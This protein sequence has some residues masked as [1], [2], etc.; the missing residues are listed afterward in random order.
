MWMVLAEEEEE[1]NKKERKI[2]STIDR[3]PGLRYWEDVCYIMDHKTFKTHFRM[4][5][6][7]F[8]IIVASLQPFIHEDK[9]KRGAGIS[10]DKICAISIW[11]LATGQSFR[12]VN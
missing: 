6:S 5:K 10:F 12:E 3:G 1:E 9:Y 4:H 7:T 2:R 8:D 11:K